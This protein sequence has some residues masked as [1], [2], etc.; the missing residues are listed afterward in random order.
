MSE[1]PLYIPRDL[2]ERSDSKNRCERSAEKT[3]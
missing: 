1:Y 3:A 2:I